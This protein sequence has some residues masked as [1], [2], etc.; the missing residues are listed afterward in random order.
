MGY[1]VDLHENRVRGSKRR[2]RRLSPLHG[3]W[4]PERSPEKSRGGWTAGVTV[5]MA[6]GRMAASTSSAQSK[7]VIDKDVGVPVQVCIFPVFFSPS[8][9]TSCAPSVVIGFAFWSHRRVAEDSGIMG[10]WRTVGE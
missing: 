1:L 9:L 6:V 10:Q 8:F 4:S 7:I 5:A 2:W 3:F